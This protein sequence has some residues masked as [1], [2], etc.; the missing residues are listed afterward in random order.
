MYTRIY[1]V[2]LCIKLIFPTL[3][4]YTIVNVF[5]AA[6]AQA[7]ELLPQDL[8]Y[9]TVG[10]TCQWKLSAFFV[11]AHEEAL[12]VEL[13]EPTTDAQQRVE[14][15][16]PTVSVALLAQVVAQVVSIS[17]TDI[18]RRRWNR[19][20]IGWPCPA[21]KSETTSTVSAT[22]S[23]K[24]KFGRAAAGRDAYRYTVLRMSLY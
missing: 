23:R 18:A 13:K 3:L 5:V 19:K 4:V 24:A 1:E 14:L 20:M 6:L 16:E 9:A 22:A 21:I 10:K 11:I 7:L 12:P 17:I 15:K 2:T 8:F